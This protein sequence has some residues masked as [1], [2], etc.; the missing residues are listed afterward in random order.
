MIDGAKSDT[1][2]KQEASPEK[3]TQRICIAQTGPLCYLCIATEGPENT[4][5]TGLTLEQFAQYV[6]DQ[7]CVN[8][9]NLDGGGSATVVF[10][11][12]KINALSTGKMR[13]LCDIIYFATAVPTK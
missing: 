11:G 4:G 1:L 10:N 2:D 9:Y 3:L 5:S 7:G 8:A 13:Q 12:S 6:Y